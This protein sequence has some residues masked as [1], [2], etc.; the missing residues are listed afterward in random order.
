M[1]AWF[2]LATFSKLLTAQSDCFWPPPF[3]HSFGGEMSSGKMLTVIFRIT[4]TLVPIQWS[5]PVL[6]CQSEASRMYVPDDLSQGKHL[7]RVAVQTAAGEASVSVAVQA[8]QQPVSHN[9]SHPSFTLHIYA[10]T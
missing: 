3:S 10:Y 1:H 4:E 6:H 2:I 8:S 7:Q 9:S 5:Q